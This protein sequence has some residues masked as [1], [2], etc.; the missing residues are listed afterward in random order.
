M[1]K[2]IIFLLILLSTNLSANDYFNTLI[3]TAFKNNYFIKSYE[4]LVE[5]SKLNIKIANSYFLP[6]INF[7]YNFTQTNEPGSAAFFKSKQGKF[8][9]SYYY[10]HMTDPPFVKNNQYIVS[11]MQPIFSKGNI[12]LSKKQAKL[13]YEAYVDSLKQ[14]KREIKF[15]IFKTLINGYKI[16]D[17][18]DIA[19]AVEKKSETYYNTI[20]NL[21]KN[22][23]ALKSD[24]LFA[25]FN[26]EK[27]KVELN[28][29]K[30]N[31]SK[32][33]NIIK[34]LTGKKFKIKKIDF[35]YSDKLNNSELINY[36][37][38]HRDD[39]NALK[40]YLEMAK[41]EIKK[42]RNE[43]LPSVYGFAQYERNSDKV[44]QKEKD[45]ITAG[46]GVK[47]NIFN[48]FRDVTNINRA[49]ESY[50]QLKNNLLNQQQTIIREIN[51][52]I[53]DFNN[54]KFAYNTY[55]SLVKSNKIALKLSEN[56]FNQGI[57]R[58]TTLTDMLTNY[59]TSLKELSKSRWELILKY[60]TC[61]FKAGKF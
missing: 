20:K 59:K 41:I 47:F 23:T 27:A 36:A 8:T 42:K 48:G 51:N 24:L 38:V 46:I 11:I 26:L 4:K 3:K 15:Q 57:E 34:Q 10:K 56:R 39:L 2:F 5:K 54:A 60:Y 28:A 61:L 49:T 53:I 32:V 37:L 13:Q 14:I 19:K 12:Y 43:Y 45:G 9:M 7:G 1:K 21:Y 35:K 25:K 40:K 31:L 50:L 33:E 18:I 55:K 58:I 16:L 44:F 17:Y 52:A 22:G 30:N 6:T 29:T